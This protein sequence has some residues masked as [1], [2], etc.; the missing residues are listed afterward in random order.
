MFD[1]FE[2]FD[3]EILKKKGGDGRIITRMPLGVFVVFWTW[4]FVNHLW[5]KIVSNGWLCDGSIWT[6]K[7]GTSW[8]ACERFLC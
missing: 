6:Y 4:P 8:Y 1:C 5:G 2:L 7:T 3:M